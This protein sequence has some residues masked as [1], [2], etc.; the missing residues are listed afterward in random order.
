MK[1][2]APCPCNVQPGFRHTSRNWTA[3]A[4]SRFWRWCSTTAIRA[5]R[6]R[7][8]ITPSLWG[9][10]GVNLFFVLSG[11]LITCI[12]LASRNQP[13]YF[14]NFHGRRALR[15]WPVYLLVLLVCYLNAQWFVGLPVREAFK[16]APWLAYVLRAEPVS[17]HFAA[18]HRPHLGAGDRGAVLL[19]L[20]AGR[21]RSAQPRMLAVLLAVALVASPLL[22]QATSAG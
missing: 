22:R 16:T 5:S 20:G 3:C 10:T 11:F 12:L 1:F 14:R 4:A 2:L 19:R 6:A 9:W 15:V 21:A 18:A 17:P 8:F 7:G 13:K